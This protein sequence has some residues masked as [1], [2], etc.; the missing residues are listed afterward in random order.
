MMVKYK[1]YNTLKQK[2]K[3]IM[4]INKFKICNKNIGMSKII[5]YSNLKNII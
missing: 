4:F 1:Y 2:I 3:K 5:N